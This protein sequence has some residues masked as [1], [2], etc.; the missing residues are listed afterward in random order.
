MITYPQEEKF[1]RE[2]ARI[3]KEAL[4]REAALAEIEAANAPANAER[5]RIAREKNSGCFQDGM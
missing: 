3:H 2:K 1:D 5:L 4:E